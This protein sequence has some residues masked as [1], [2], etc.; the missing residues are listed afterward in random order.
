MNKTEIITFMKANPTC[1]LATLEGNAPRVRAIDIYKVSEKEIIIQTNVTKD[2]NKQ[3]LQNPNIEI[4]FFNKQAGRNQIRVRGTVEP[5]NDPAML[6]EVMEDRPFL[7]NAA[8]QGNGPALF[9][10]KRP[11]AYV[12][13]PETNYA[14][15]AFIA[16]Y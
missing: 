13:S 12:W 1:Y 14:R 16:L 5:L 8:S 4:L 11:L 2:L 3:M 7:K 6:K 9:R 10:V 15:K